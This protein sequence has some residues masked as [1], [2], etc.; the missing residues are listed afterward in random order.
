MFTSEIRKFF[1]I[2]IFVAS[3]S[4]NAGES[5]SD[6]FARLD[7]RSHE[8]LV[9]MLR[10]HGTT[11]TDFADV[12][13]TVSPPE[14]GRS[15]P[16]VSFETPKRPNANEARVLLFLGGGIGLVHARGLHLLGIRKD[17]NGRF[18]WFVEGG[19][20][21]LT[22]RFG[23]YPDDV[24]FGAGVFP[25]K[26]PTVGIALK[27]HN[28]SYSEKLGVGPELQINRFIGKKDAIRL[29]T[30]ISSTV[31]LGEENLKGQNYTIAPDVHVGASVRFWCLK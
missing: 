29:F 6:F 1:A 27:I 17:A 18:A 22:P 24:S 4:A 3:T 16:T 23:S 7:S 20:E 9:E 10:E 31:Y 11:P 13:F 5:V 14:P 12:A 2:L 28:S 26:K 30:R 8:N 19:L 15:E 21:F 25:F